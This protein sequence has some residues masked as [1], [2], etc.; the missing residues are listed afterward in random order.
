MA[1]VQNKSERRN[2]FWKFFLFFLIS[3]AA[4]IGAVFFNFE[5]PRA[6]NKILKKEKDNIEQ[7][8]NAQQ[9]FTAAISDANDLL[10]SLSQPGANISY[11][12]QLISTKLADI[13]KI[14][15]SD[16][17]NASAKLNKVILDIMLKYQQTKTRLLS[18]NDA[19]KENEK[20][21]TDLDKCN[22]DLEDARKT[23]EIYRRSNNQ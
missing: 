20:M 19:L 3:V 11:T 17:S 9:K 14:Q 13:T 16:S 1:Q 10:D 21:K 6:E 7:T 12:N 8:M 22:S 18:V 23:I 2:A 15:F 5:M 4:T